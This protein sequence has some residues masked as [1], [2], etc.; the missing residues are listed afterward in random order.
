MDL[1]SLMNTFNLAIQDCTEKFSDI[2]NV[3][4]I[5]TN[6]GEN[7]ETIMQITVTMINHVEFDSLKIYLLR[8]VPLTMAWG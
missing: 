8:D 6:K 4:V 5:I 2:L 3:R 1:R 7:R